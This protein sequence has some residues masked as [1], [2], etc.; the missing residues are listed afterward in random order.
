M[1]TYNLPVLLFIMLTATILTGCTN[2]L[3]YESAEQA[4]AA[5]DYQN[6][7]DTFHHYSTTDNPL[8]YQAL[9]YEGMSNYNLGLCK[10]AAKD[11]STVIEFSKNRELR[12]RSL[13]GRAKSYLKMNTPNKAAEDY[14]TLLNMYEDIFPVDQALAGI[15]TA[16]KQCGDASGAYEYEERLRRDYPKSTALQGSSGVGSIWR[17]RVKRKY[18]TKPTAQTEIDKLKNQGFETALFREFSQGGDRFVIQ[19]GAFASRTSAQAR[20]DSAHALGWDTEVVRR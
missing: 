19:I 14:L 2:P 4:Y 17:V 16:K 10:E 11:F 12:A 5:G 8:R 9:Y 15:V 6:A 1:R 7:K 3:P 20:A 18:L 13:E